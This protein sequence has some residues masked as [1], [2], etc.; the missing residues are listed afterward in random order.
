M[1]AWHEAQAQA[2]KQHDTLSPAARA[3]QRERLDVQREQAAGKLTWLQAEKEMR[4]AAAELEAQHLRSPSH[5]IGVRTNAQRLHEADERELRDARRAQSAERLSFVR[6]QKE[7]QAAAEEAERAEMLAEYARATQQ[8]KQLEAG[9]HSL[10]KRSPADVRAGTPPRGLQQQATQSPRQNRAGSPRRDPGS[11]SIFERLGAEQKADA[12]AKREAELLKREMSEMRDGPALPPASRRLTRNVPRGDALGR[13]SSPLRSDPKYRST[14]RRSDEL[15]T[16]QFGTF[17]AR[18]MPKYGEIHMLRDF[19]NGCRI[20]MVH[21]ADVATDVYS[22]VGTGLATVESPGMNT[23]EMQHLRRQLAAVRTRGLD[24]ETL[25]LVKGLFASID[26]KTGGALLGADDEYDDGD[27]MDAM[28]VSTPGLAHMSGEQ[29][30]PP[31]GQKKRQQPRRRKMAR[32]RQPARTSSPRRQAYGRRPDD[33]AHTLSR[34]PFVRF[35]AGFSTHFLGETW[36][37]WLA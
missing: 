12:H 27:E 22:P 20:A 3:Q 29:R 13:L 31:S 36:R 6:A 10:T 8:R 7:V 19:E 32:A 1:S 25:E 16:D 37:R 21:G 17:K 33:G 11:P 4:P 30:R 24:E 14:A 34:P 9:M 2:T 35:S 15:A 26:A 28:A 23:G 18:P 5:V